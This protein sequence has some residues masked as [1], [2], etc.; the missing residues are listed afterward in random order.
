MGPPSV[1][2]PASAL[3]TPSL[4]RLLLMLRRFR[5]A[6]DPKSQAPTMRKSTVVLL[7]LSDNLKGILLSVSEE[8]LLS[9]CCLSLGP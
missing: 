4:G 2:K 1:V 3:S 6:S 8:V 7:G 5:Y 9:L